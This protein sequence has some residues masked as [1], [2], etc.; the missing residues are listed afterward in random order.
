MRK[1]LIYIHTIAFL[2]T[3][4]CNETRGPSSGGKLRDKPA[5]Y[6]SDVVREPSTIVLDISASS[7]QEIYAGETRIA[8]DQLK[9]ILR[10]LTENEGKIVVNV[11]ML[12]SFGLREWKTEF[13]ETLALQ[14]FSFEPWYD[15][16]NM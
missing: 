4:S 9:E 7:T 10:V 8:T 12:K 13:G 2:F 16:D 3:I 11:R 6:I 15:L 1:N 14:Q 5:K